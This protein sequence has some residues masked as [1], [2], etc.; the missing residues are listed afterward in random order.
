MKDS[1]QISVA[2][3]F[4]ILFFSCN[5]KKIDIDVVE[6]FKY[7]KSIKEGYITL[8]GEIFSDS[9]NGDYLYC[10]NKRNGKHLLF[11]RDLKQGVYVKVFEF[12]GGV[13]SKQ[14]RFV[15]CDFDSVNDI[16]ITVASGGNYDSEIGIIFLKKGNKFLEIQQQVSYP[17]FDNRTNLVLSRYQ[18]PNDTSITIEK[19]KWA[20]DSLFFLN[21]HSVNDIDYINDNGNLVTY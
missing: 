7:D 2:F 21:R 17:I 10:F 13:G 20:R 14:A 3:A 11:Q 15:D 16:L 4:F 19:Y 6:S 8:V 18:G 12:D 1:F 5:E 9:V